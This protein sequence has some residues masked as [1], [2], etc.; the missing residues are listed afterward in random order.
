MDMF[1]ALDIWM[2][3]HEE[4]LYCRKRLVRRY[5]KLLE[6]DREENL[7]FGLLME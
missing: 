5:L 2:A 6:A 7:D 3:G 1:K 4:E